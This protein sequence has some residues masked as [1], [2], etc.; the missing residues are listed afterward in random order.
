MTLT[1][2]ITDFLHLVN[3][4]PSPHNGQPM[5]IK[6][7]DDESFEVYFETKRGLQSSEVSY[8]FSFVT[9][10]LFAKYIEQCASAFGFSAEMVI[11]LPSVKDMRGDKLLKCFKVQLKESGV[12]DEKLRHALETRHTSRKKYKSGVDEQTFKTIQHLIP[13]EMRLQKLDRLQAHKAI[14]LNQRAVFDDMFDEPVRKEL[15]HWLRYTQEEKRTKK[16]GLAYDCMELNGKA[17]KAIVRKPSILHM[18]ILRTLIRQYYLRTMKD[19]SDVFYVM[20]PFASELDAFAVGKMVMDVW[21]CLS[22]AG[23]YL[24][25]FGTI[26]SNEHA[27]RDFLKLVHELDE[28]REKSYLVFI[29]RAGASD[30][31]VQSMRLPMEDHLLLKAER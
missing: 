11:S 14:W 5:R 6:L 2:K 22:I 26:M 19:N 20:A 18:P 21:T 10:G 27:H 25:P 24:H 13:P 9:I 4:Y 1:Q 31:P 28:S 29:F 8:I 3:R 15:D 12:A 7:L 23:M 16:D 30:V 17:M